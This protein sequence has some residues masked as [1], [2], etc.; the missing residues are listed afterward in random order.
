ME[1][2]YSLSCSQKQPSV[3]IL[4]YSTSLPPILHLEDPFTTFKY[5]PYNWSISFSF[6][7]QKPVVT[8]LRPYAYYMS[9]PFISFDL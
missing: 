6:P 2:G 4:N 5:R 1:P 9:G 8:S 7:R 3:P